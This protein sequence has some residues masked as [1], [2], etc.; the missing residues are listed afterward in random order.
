M[1]FFQSYFVEKTQA[2]LAQLDGLKDTTG[3]EKEIGYNEANVDD[4]YNIGYLVLGG[5]FWKPK[6]HHR[7]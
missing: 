1:F 7:N 6:K 5:S 3:V 4:F 2:F